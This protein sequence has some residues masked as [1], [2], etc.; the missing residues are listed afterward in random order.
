MVIL[1]VL[2][3]TTFNPEPTLYPPA[4]PPPPALGVYPLD[5]ALPPPP[6]P[7]TTRNSISVTPSGTTNSPELLNTSVSVEPPVRGQ[8]P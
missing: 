2:P 8:T 5:G 6:P 1:I 3:A 7:A 4:P